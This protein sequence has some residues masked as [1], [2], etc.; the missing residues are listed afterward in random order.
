MYRA[1]NTSKIK[2]TDLENSYHVYEAYFPQ[3]LKVLHR[4]WKNYYYCMWFWDS[5]PRAL[6]LCSLGRHSIV[7]ATLLSLFC[8]G[9]FGHLHSWGLA[10]FAPA[11]MEPWSSQSQP[12]RYL[13]INWDDRHALLCPAI[14]W[15]GGPSNSLSRLD[16]NC[17][18]PNLS[19][20]TS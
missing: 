8:S 7:W 9:Y 16:L 20:P 11:G 15:D 18:P 13:G 14:G 4:L 2:G 17:D 3:L 19:L 6:A 12:P 10:N 5:K 1:E